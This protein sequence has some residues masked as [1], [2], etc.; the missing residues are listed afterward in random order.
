MWDLQML[1]HLNA[2]RSDKDLEQ[3]VT[4]AALNALDDL[5]LEEVA[6]RELYRHSDE[7][8]CHFRAGVRK[9]S[10]KKP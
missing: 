2:R 7:L 1:R 3:V 6:I 5:D 8:R 9:Y 4:L 10:R